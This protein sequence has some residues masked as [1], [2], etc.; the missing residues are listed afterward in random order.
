MHVDAVVL[1][2]QPIREHDQLVTLY[3]R[4][5]GKMSVLAKGSLQRHS[6]QALAL[7]VGNSIQCELV[8]GRAGVLMT[9]AQSVQCRSY[10]KHTPTGMAALFAITHTF[11]AVVFDAQADEQLWQWLTTALAAL[12]QA[13]S[14]DELQVVR[15]Q[16][17]AFLSVLGYGAQTWDAS[18]RAAPSPLDDA[19]DRIAQRRV[20]ATDLLYRL[21]DS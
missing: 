6:K 13:P 16:Q 14:G 21:I 4:Q 9:G 20:G 1:R 8:A 17:A 3:T 7:D 5:S 2:V 18:W 10:A 11:T 19:I 12:D 15:A